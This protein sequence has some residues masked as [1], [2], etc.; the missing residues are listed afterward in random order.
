MAEVYENFAYYILE[1]F[2]NLGLCSRIWNSDL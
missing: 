2:I 1:L